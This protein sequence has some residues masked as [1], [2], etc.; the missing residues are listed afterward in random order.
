M[1]TI[2][3]E[4]VFGCDIIKVMGEKLALTNTNWEEYPTNDKLIIS[5][6]FVNL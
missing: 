5:D 3:S 2:D 4:S 1:Q 6:N